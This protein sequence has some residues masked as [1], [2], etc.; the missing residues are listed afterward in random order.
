[1]ARPIQTAS[2]DHPTPVLNPT[3]HP[4]IM[5]PQLHT[6][7]V[8][9]KVHTAK[10]DSCDKHNKLTMYRCVDCGQH[11]CSLCWN[12][13]SGDRNHV[14]RSGVRA[15]PA[16]NVN[17]VF[18]DDEVDGERNNNEKKG[19]A[20][21]RGRRVISDDDDDD[22]VP[23]LTPAPT[24]ENN[25][26]TNAN[27]QHL[28]WK[29][30]IMNNDQHEDHEGGLPTL[31]PIL[32][33]RSLPAL[34][35]AAQAVNTNATESTNRAT[36]RRPHAHAEESDPE[37]PR[38]MRVYDNQ[39][40]QMIPS[41]Y[42]FVEDEDDDDDTNHQPRRPSHSTIP[43]QQALRPAPPHPQPAT[44]GPRPRPDVDRQAARNQWAF[45]NSPPTNHQAPRPAQP[46][47][48]TQQAPQLAPSS[49]P[50]GFYR[51]R[52]GVDVDRQA[53]RNQ[54]AFANPPGFHRSP[55]G[56]DVDRQ[57]ARNQLAFANPRPKNHQA[58]Q[59]SDPNQQTVRRAPL[60]AAR[61][62]HA[63][64][65]AQNA[66]DMAARYAEPF[67]TS[68]S[69]EAYENARQTMVHNRQSSTS[70]QDAQ[71]A[72]DRD[73][74]AAH[75]Q[76]AFF[77][78]QRSSSDVSRLEQAR[79]QNAYLLHLLRQQADRPA[80]GVAQSSVSY[81]VAA[82][83]SP[84]PAEFLYSQQRAALL[85]SRQAQHRRDI[86]DRLNGSSGYIPVQEVCPPVPV[87]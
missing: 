73:R 45:A 11:V 48:T 76:Q 70:H 77:S 40:R 43:L 33:A 67:D 23:V 81:P 80:G 85:A 25:E 49:I 3:A 50:P 66:A 52:P 56:V 14:F 84:S 63:Q 86:Q 6:D 87:V 8:E 4:P 20:R 75:N 15:A 18:G 64:Q 28:K 46:T 37:H 19:R 2:V 83:S 41:R 36:Q 78:N 35:P 55:P 22:D 16:L 12:R 5:S 72:A 30:V 51:P 57:A 60:P 53:A 61:L 27:K 34:R 17:H 74:V 7:F 58:P 1:M 29:T 59:P 71:P 24:T 21:A 82:D 62:S 44:Y 32:P 79:E 13:K 47:T 65:R 31:W 42:A 39:G 69:A 38:I 26:A 10:C 9:V 68:Q 54:W